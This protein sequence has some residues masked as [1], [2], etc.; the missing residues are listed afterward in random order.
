MIAGLKV[1]HTVVQSGRLGNRQKQAQPA[2]LC[3]ANSHGSFWCHSLTAK[4]TSCFCSLLVNFDSMK[5][6]PKNTF[7]SSCLHSWSKQGLGSSAAVV[8]VATEME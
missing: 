3:L 1:N 4:L 5:V 8:L 7:M 2:L 6:A